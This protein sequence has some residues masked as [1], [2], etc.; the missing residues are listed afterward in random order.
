MS[1]FKHTSFQDRQKSAAESK[2]ALLAKFHM[3]PAADD[4][5]VLEREAQRQ[6]IVV[7]REARAVER[8]VR[9]PKSTRRCRRG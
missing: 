1:A 9:K 3:R 7:A 5:V 4:P 6:A 2:K 8:A